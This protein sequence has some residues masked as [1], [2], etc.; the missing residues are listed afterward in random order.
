MLAATVLLAGL[1]AFARGASTP[2]SG[3]TVNVGYTTLLGNASVP[4]VHFY[5]GIRYAVPPLGNLRWRAPQPLDERTVQGSKKNV[6]DARWFGDI[7]LQQPAT[8]GTDGACS[9]VYQLILPLTNAHF[10]LDCLTLNVWKPANAK[11][12]DKVPVVI[13]IH[14]GLPVPTVSNTS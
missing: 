9:C 8:L 6:T 14:V 1:S 13:Y 11:K 2:S 4:G 7:C 3:P 5:G 10:P 12:G